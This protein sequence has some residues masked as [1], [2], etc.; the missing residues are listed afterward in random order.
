M[1]KALH[2]TFFGASVTE[3]S[4]H[5]A[6]GEVTG[7]VNYY[8]Q[9]FAR[10]KNITVSRVSAGSCNL[11][12][13][14]II[15][16]N[17]VIALKP[18]IC[19][20]DWATTAITDC[21]MR[22][23]N[24][25]YNLLIANRIVTLTVILPRTDRVQ[26]ET[27]IADKMRRASYKFGMP[28]HDVSVMISSDALSRALRDIVHTSSE[29]AA[30]YANFID[31]FITAVDLES[32]TFPTEAP[33]FSISEIAKAAVTPLVAKQIILSAGRES[34]EDIEYSV[35]LEQRIGPYSPVLQIVAGQGSESVLLQRFS[36]WDPWCYRERQCL[37]PLMEWA[38]GKL[39]KVTLRV[40]N[41]D[42]DYSKA[43]E[44]TYVEPAARHIKPRGSLYLV[45]TQPIQCSVEF[46]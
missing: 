46:R 4:V 44:P 37:K 42:P 41:D 35:M 43:K 6:T 26:S 31:E 40:C 25:V 18:D 30:I 24:Q 45:S 22:F 16:V 15:Y 39:S 1:S 36:L 29:G 14:A 8:E 33:P 19:V 3:Q 10:E 9:N 23:V 34:A 2:V 5:H 27:L 17:K 32:Y 13:A 21:D 28:F 20:I 38:S 11:T 7:Y 12:D